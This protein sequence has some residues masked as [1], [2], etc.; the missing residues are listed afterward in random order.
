M[1]SAPVVVAGAVAW[2]AGQA[3]AEVV[4]ASGDVSTGNVASAVEVL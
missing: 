4:V 1:A 2:Q 3:V